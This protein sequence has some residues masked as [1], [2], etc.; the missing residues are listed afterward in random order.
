MPYSYTTS[1]IATD[2]TASGNSQ[3][4]KAPIDSAFNT[5]NTQITINTAEIEQGRGVYSSLAAHF[6]ALVLSGGNVAT[7]TV[8]PISAAQKVVT[9]DS[10]TGF[11]AGGRVAYLLAGGGIEYN[12]IATVDSGS[13]L[14]LGTNIGA[15]GIGDN[16]YFTLIGE[17]EYQAAVAIN[18]GGT[19]VATL[20]ANIA[21]LGRKVY[22][23]QAYGMS[24]AATAAA[25]T[26]ALTAALT[27]AGSAGGG[28]VVLPAGAMN[29]NNVAFQGAN[30][31]LVG[32]GMPSINA[33]KTALVG[34]TVLK[35]GSVTFGGY[36]GG[37]I[38]DLG[39]D[40]SGVS[41]QNAISSGTSTTG[42]QRCVV[43][44][45]IALG[46]G[47]IDGSHGLV[48]TSGDYNVVE[49]FSAYKVQHGLALRSSWNR[50][51]DCYFYDCSI[52]SIFIKSLD[53]GISGGV[54]FASYNTISNVQTES[55]ALG[56]CGGIWLTAQT[57]SKTQY[58]AISNYVAR[59]P[60]FGIVARASG[61]G[62]CSYNTISGGA[63]FWPQYRAIDL[64][65]DA[66]EFTFL[67]MHVSCLFGSVILNNSNSKNHYFLGGTALP[68][69]GERLK[70]G[71]IIQFQANGR[72]YKISLQKETQ[73]IANDTWTKV[74][75]SN[76]IGSWNEPDPA[77]AIT[78]ITKDN[79]AEVTAANHGFSNGHEVYMYGVGGM[80]ELNNRKYKVTNKTT[81]TFQLFR[82]TDLQLISI[83]GT[84]TVT[85][86][87][88]AAHN[89]TT[90]AEVS[91]VNTEHFDGGPYAI[92]VTAADAFTYS[93]NGHAT[94]E[95][96]GTV[97]TAYPSIDS[98]GYTT[99]TGGGSVRR[100]LQQAFWDLDSS[101]ANVSGNLLSPGV[102]DLGVNVR[103]QFA[104]H[105]TG[106]RRIRLVR[107][108][109]PSTETVE[110][111]VSKTALSAYETDLNLFFSR[112]VGDSQYFYIEAY[113]N[114]GGNLNVAGNSR[115]TVE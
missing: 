24:A 83:S 64:G 32:A 42:V 93:A 37:T 85:V 81:N 98:S 23:A 72:P 113:Q 29:I 6:A 16:V 17:S 95:T 91:I 7:L 56:V 110:T 88:S 92:T 27:A 50:V 69:G 13:Q 66:D 10:T 45:V 115:I 14:T 58:N 51:S 48:V 99:Y 75:W 89:L 8:G 60:A 103:I 94:A 90:G 80:V 67:G 59:Q 73:S 9:V 76:L 53:Y 12:T 71:K 68:L 87:T 62:E 108:V 18:Y 112:K 107:H 61:G 31:A 26:T 22:L 63:I 104:T 11:I 109:P 46:A 3:I 100:Y 114:S 105:A 36:A 74:K 77:V 52:S 55:S 101:D 38:R 78:A 35:G 15:G 40:V 20:P 54:D 4:R 70:K 34:G 57:G 79:P 39:V 82:A 5:A 2:I 111:T 19:Y 43:Q 28:V 25:N 84:G 86:Q 33:D 30:V 65:G 44:N 97:E 49:N 47:Q 41:G 96:A 21:A 102:R 1:P 106:V